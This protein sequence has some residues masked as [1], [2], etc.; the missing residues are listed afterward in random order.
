MSSP[1]YNRTFHFP[2]SEG[3]SS[4]DKIALDISG[5]IG[6]QIV[7]S[8][9]LDGSNCSLEHSGCF[10]RTHSGPPVHES[11]DGLK[12]MHANIKHKIPPNIQLFGEWVFAK[13]S[14]NYSELPSYF[15]LFNVRD[16]NTNTWA[17]WDEVEL[18]AQEIETHTVPVLFKGEV[19]S[20]IELQKMIK[21]F[22]IQSS[23]CGGEMEGVVV[24]V[25]N[26][27]NDNDFATSVFKMV[28]KN[29]VQTSEHWTNQTI[30]R[31]LIKK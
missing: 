7:I 19:K 18:W 6:K 2:F 31:N 14:I 15:M 10:A 4:D 16:L 27:F 26:E 12:A 22:M 11:F 28:R 20:D 1:K 24:R 30:I 9:K 17:S 29:H 8:E 13:H 25:A 23:K 5:V 3:A 21:S